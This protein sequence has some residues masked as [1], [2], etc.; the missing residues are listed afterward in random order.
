MTQTFEQKVTDYDYQYRYEYTYGVLDTIERARATAEAV[1]TATTDTIL[2]E[3]AVEWRLRVD[4]DV[5]DQLYDVSPLVDTANPFGD[6]CVLKLDDQGGELFDRFARGTRV[7]VDISENFGLSFDN[8]FTGFVV[9]RRE[10]EQAGADAL[11]IEAYSFDQFL[12]KN[13]VTNDQSGKTLRAA[14]EDI[15]K[16]DTPVSFVG[17]NIEVGNPQ[18]VQ[19]TLRGRKVENVLQGLAFASTGEE[20]GVNDDL[21]FFFRPPETVHIERGVDNTQWFNYNI[22]ELGKDAIN[23][24]EVFFNNGN[25]SV[26]VDRGKS[27]L[28][29]Q[30]ELGLPD[31]ATERKELNRDDIDTFEGAKQ[32]GEQFLEFRNTVLTGTVTTF[33]LFDAR[34]GDTID[35]SIQ[36]RGIDDEFRIAELSYEWGRD[37]TTITIVEK[38]SQ[39]IDTDILRVSD[40]VDRIEQRGADRDGIQNRI[41][42]TDVAVTI[43]PSADVDGTAA[44]RRRLTNAGRNYVR[45][46]FAGDSTPAISDIAVGGSNAN[47]SRSNTALEDETARANVTTGGSGTTATFAASLNQTDVREVGLFASNT[48]ITRLTLAD[49]VNVSGSVTVTL[50]VDNDPSVD[51]GVFTTTGQESV[52]DVLASDNPDLPVDYRYGRGQTLPQESDTA[53]DTPAATLS[54]N[55]VT[56]QTADI[57]SEFTNVIQTDLST[58]THLQV[59][60]GQLQSL[61]SLSLDT[62]PSTNTSFTRPD[63][64]ATPTRDT[65]ADNAENTQYQAILSDSQ[66]VEFSG[67]QLPVTIPSNNATVAVRLFKEIGA[68]NNFNAAQNPIQVE[69]F[70]DNNRVRLL[71]VFSDLSENDFQFFTAPAQT[72]IDSST[73]LTIAITDPFASFGVNDP[74]V[75]VDVAA[76]FNNNFSYNFPGSVDANNRLAGPELFPDVQEVVYETASTRRPVSSVTA[77]EG[78]NNTDGQQFIAVSNDGGATFQRFDNTD[79]AT[80]NF[81]DTNTSPKAKLGLSRGGSRTATSPTQ[82][83]IGQTVST[84]ELLGGAE[85]ITPTDIGAAEARAIARTGQLSSES[86]QLREGGQLDANGDLLTRSI[87]PS[88][89]I[90]SQ[91]RVESSEQTRFE[92]D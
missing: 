7:E 19:E 59:A 9:E 64:N 78:Y 55:T 62:A 58:K 72:S 56:V 46:G 8:R 47:L 63:A 30:N 91:T 53:L 86:D 52:R 20:F 1:T 4:G 65:E 41:T 67:F 37:A 88:F 92:R 15:V 11:E 27:K 87:F 57:N 14:L 80:G 42:N 75:G 50:D 28:D 66:T 5:I 25:E 22:P 73:S 90:G 24:V 61:K 77:N 39:D 21:E 18:T 44:D 3:S 10:T 43:T 35:I 68:D 13:T 2:T 81:S 36:S 45:D 60:S 89:P 17:S 54:L 69:I 51:R 71:S 16:T 48:L 85:G 70:V 34:P 79:E 23:E 82:G 32:A 33:G 49:P 31:P 12:R 6:Y 26:V 74:G 38:R 40:K 83:F 84:H 76:I 29:L